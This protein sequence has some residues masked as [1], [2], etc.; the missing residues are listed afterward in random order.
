MQVTQDRESAEDIFRIVRRFWENLPDE[1]RK[2]LF[3]NFAPQCAAVGV[4]AIWTASIVWRRRRRMRD[5]GGRSRICIVRRFR[6]GG[7]EGDEALASLRAAVVPGGNIVLESTPNG[8]GGLF[9]E[10]WQRAEETGYTR[11]FF[12][13]WYD[14]AYVAGA[15]REFCAAHGGRSGAGGAARTDDRTDRVATETMGVVA[16]TGGAGICRGSGV[17]LPG[18]G[19]MR[20]RPGGGG[21]GAWGVGRTAG[22]ARQ[23]AADDL[24]AGA[25][26]A[27]VCDRSRSGGRRE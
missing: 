5:E 16:W 22:D 2:G 10:E 6:A 9:Y 26:G 3:E 25:A 7:G 15:G 18:V 4:S 27:G 11:H 1:A 19:R 12:P 17:V 8:A 24:A 13:W 23:R 14:A 20:V 21:E